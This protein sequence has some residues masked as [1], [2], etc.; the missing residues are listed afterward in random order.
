MLLT[1]FLTPLFLLITSTLA[2]SDYQD[3][4]A[5]A[6]KNPSTNAAISKFCNKK[7]PNGGLINDIT[8]PGSRSSRGV[9]VDG[10]RIRLTG[11]CT[12]K[13]WVPLQYCQTQLHE[14]CALSPHKKGFYTRRYGRG[15]CQIW[16]IESAN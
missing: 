9:S 4:L 16:S 3:S 10:I 13:Q 8:V 5:C 1:H 15:G 11:D 6:K 2:A 12:P 7:G 14:M